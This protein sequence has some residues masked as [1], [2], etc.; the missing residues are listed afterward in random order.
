[1]NYFGRIGSAVFFATRNFAPVN[2]ARPDKLDRS[3]V[4]VGRENSASEDEI[5]YIY[6]RSR[7]LRL[8]TREGESAKLNSYHII[9]MNLSRK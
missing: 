8:D 6:T 9:K 3:W 2:F 7:K 1:M 5:L 4:D